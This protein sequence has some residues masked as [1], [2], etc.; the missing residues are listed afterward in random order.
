MRTH[1]SSPHH[2]ERRQQWRL[3]RA[4]KE[5][6]R[7][8][9]YCD[10]ERCKYNDAQTCTQNLVYYVGRKCMTYRDGRHHET[11]RLMWTSERTG[12]RKRGG[13]YVSD[14]RRVIK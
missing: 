6:G 8:K 9:I 14:G 11:S 2:D 12:C 13:R 4:Q 10:N 3:F 7:V 5:A 1:T